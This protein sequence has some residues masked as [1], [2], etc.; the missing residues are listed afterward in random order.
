MVKASWRRTKRARSAAFC[1]AVDAAAGSF[2]DLTRWPYPGCVGIGREYLAVW[3]QANCS[4]ACS[5]SSSPIASRPGVGSARVRIAA[6]ARPQDAVAAV[7]GR[8]PAR[9]ARWGR[10]ARPTAC[11]ARSRGA[12]RRCRRRR[13]GRR[14]ATTRGELAQVGAARQHVGGGEPGARRDHARASARSSRAAGDD[15]PPAR[16]RARRARRRP[17]A[18]AASGAPALAAPGWTTRR[19]A[20]AAAAAR[21]RGQRRRS[22]RVGGDPVAR[23]QPAPARDLVL[24]RR[25]RPGRRGRVGVREGDQPPRAR[26]RA[27]RAWLSGPRPCRLTARSAPRGRGRQRR[28]SGAAVHAVVDRVPSRARDERRERARAREHA[29]VRRGTRARS[30]RSAGTPVSRS[31]SPSARRTTSGGGVTARTAPSDGRHDQLAHLA[32]PAGGCSAKTTACGDVSAGSLSSASGAGLVLLGRGRRRSGVRMPPGTSSV[33]PTRP[34]E[35]GRERAREADDAEL[36]RAVGGRVA[37]ARAARASRR[38]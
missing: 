35:L 17:S 22:R 16:A 38:R 36:A 32:R 3:A 14:A 18:P 13:R 11:R 19:A 7:R 10:R 37:A 1:G 30:A 5:T 21:P 2:E 6:P 20:G 25:A 12:R 15:H 26:P 27:A 8:S 4:S 23:Q 9:A 31:P 28:G 33:T 29:A 24:V 34:A